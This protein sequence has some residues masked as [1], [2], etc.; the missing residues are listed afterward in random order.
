MFLISKVII[1][2]RKTKSIIL[3]IYILLIKHLFVLNIN[4]SQ[5]INQINKI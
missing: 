1:N 3:F 4:K 2:S 5:A